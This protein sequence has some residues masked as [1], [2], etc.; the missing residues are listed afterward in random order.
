MFHTFCSTCV[1]F[2]LQFGSFPGTRQTRTLRMRTTLR[3][4]THRAGAPHAHTTQ[5]AKE[6][7][8]DT[9]QEQARHSA[10]CVATHCNTLQHAA[11]HCNT[12]QLTATHLFA[13][14]G[15][16]H[17]TLRA[18]VEIAASYI[19]NAV[20]TGGFECVPSALVKILECPPSSYPPEIATRNLAARGMWSHAEQV[21]KRLGTRCVAVCC[22][23][24]PCVAVSCSELQF[25][26]LCMCEWSHAEQVVKRLGNRCVAVCCS[27]L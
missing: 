9:E 16:T 13:S 10:P 20:K 23:V 24:L 4:R 6:N 17:C 5:L 12:L 2:H 19:Q 27:V 3:T 26:A 15:E 8:Q 21:V 1:L 14:T 18:T 22:R 7:R 11:T 25:V